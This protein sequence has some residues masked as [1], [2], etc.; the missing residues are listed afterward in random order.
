MLDPA[1]VTQVRTFYLHRYMIAV[2]LNFVLRIFF[3]LSVDFHPENFDKYDLCVMPTL[4]Y[5]EI[6][7]LN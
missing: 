3:Q 5:M 4:D 1:R 2:A 6:S 7:R